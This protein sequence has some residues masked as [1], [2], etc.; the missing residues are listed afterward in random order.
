MNDIM[1]TKMNLNIHK[2]SS[3]SFTNVIQKYKVKIEAGRSIVKTNLIQNLLN[4]IKST[5]INSYI[6]F[7]KTCKRAFLKTEILLQFRQFS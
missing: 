6:E 7:F 3:T 4:M 2:K 1:L 5:I